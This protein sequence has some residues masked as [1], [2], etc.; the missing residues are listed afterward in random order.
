MT[1]ATLATYRLPA[2]PADVTRL[3][4]TYTAPAAV[5]VWERDVQDPALW[6]LLNDRG[7]PTGVT[8]RLGALL[9]LAAKVEVAG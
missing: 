8:S 3:S 9:D 4:A 6:H 2:V 5:V 7:N 1:A